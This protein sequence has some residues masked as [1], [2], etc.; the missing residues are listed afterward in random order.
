MTIFFWLCWSCEML[1]A[2]FWVASELKLTYLKPN[3]FSFL[4]VLYL[5]LA[6]AFRFAFEMPAM[7]NA[8]VFVP[9]IPLILLLLIFVIH[10]MSGTKWN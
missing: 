9:A 1:A 8:M 4:S 5:L 2:L 7:S 6:L 3:P 10:A